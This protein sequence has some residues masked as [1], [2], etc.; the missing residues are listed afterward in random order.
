MPQ[1]AL[2]PVNSPSITS[3]GDKSP[4]IGPLDTNDKSGQSGT[5]LSATVTA[6]IHNIKSYPWTITKTVIPDSWNLF[7]GDIATSQY[8]VDVTKGD[9]IVVES[10]LKGNVVVTNG[11]SQATEGLTIVLKVESSSGI[12]TYPVD[13]SA[14]STLSALES[15]SYSYNIPLSDLGTVTKVTADVTITN[16]SGHLNSP[17]GPNPSA[18]SIQGDN[19]PTYIHESVKVTDSNGMTWTTSKSDSWKY[20]KD[21]G[22]Y[23]SIGKDTIHNTIQMVDSNTNDVLGTASADV[24]INIYDVDP[25]KTVS[26]TFDRK[27]NWD[28]TKTANKDQLDLFVGQSGSIDYTVTVTS[29][30]YVD[31][32]WYMQGNIVVTNNAPIDAKLKSVTDVLDPLY[33]GETVTVSYNGI[34]V[35][36]D[37]DLVVPKNGGKLTFTYS[38]SLVKGDARAN[39]ATAVFKNYKY[40]VDKSSTVSGTTTEFSSRVVGV[41]FVTPAQE[42]DKSVTVTDSYKGAL[43]QVNFADGSKTFT[44]TRAVAA[45][46]SVGTKEPLKNTATITE[47]NQ[48][49]SVTVPVTVYSLGVSKDAVASYD[50]TYLWDITK[51]AD[52]TS[53]NLFVGQ[54]GEINYEVIVSSLGVS[55]TNYH[56]A[57]TITVKNNAPMVATI[58]S[59]TDVVSPGITA[60]V[61]SYQVNGVP[62]KLPYQLGAG[63]TLTC[64]YSAGLPDAADRTNTATVAIAETTTTFSGTADVKLTANE[65]DKSVTVT[66]TNRAGWSQTVDYVEGM[67]PVVYDYKATVG[68]YT[69]ASGAGAPEAT[70][71]NTATY[72]AQSGATD[73]AS[74]SVD[75]YTYALTVSKTAV[76][77]FDRTYKWTITK[78]ADPTRFDLFVGQSGSVDYT[79]TVAPDTPV[80]SNFGVSG[81]ITVSNPAPM[82]ATITNIVDSM[83]GATVVLPE[84]KVVPADG[85]RTFTY[86]VDP[87]GTKPASSNTAT[88]SIQ[89]TSITFSSDPVA[90]MF[91]S[92]HPTHE[93]D[94]TVSVSDSYSGTLGTA[95][96]NVP[97][98]QTFSYTRTLGPY[99][100]A[101]G[102]DTPEAT[103]PNTA[104]FVTS[105]TKATGSDSASVDV[106]TYSL[107]VSKDAI[108]SFD[109]TYLWDITKTA[110]PT[111]M[112]LFVGQ[113]GEINYEV[114]VSS[115]GYTDTN[116]HVAGTITVK[117]NAPMAATINSITDVVSPSIDA[118]VTG[119]KVNGESVSLPYQLAAGATLT[120]TYR[121]NLPDAVDRTNTATV[122]IDETKTTFSGTVDVTLTVNEIDKSVT[123]TDQFNGA[124]TVDTLGTV[125]YTEDMSPVTFSG[126]S[127]LTKSVGP[128]DTPTTTP[129]DIKNVATITTSTTHKS[130]DAD[131]TVQI[132]VV[133]GGK[134]LGYKFYDT[135]LNGEM[136]ANELGIHNWK[137]S[138]TSINDP[139]FVAQE[140][141][142][143]ENG[144]YLFENLPAGEY[145]VK[146]LFPSTP[147]YVGTKDTSYTVTLATGG[148]EECNFGNVALTPGVGGFTI[149]FW[150]NKNGQSLI[151]KDDLVTLNTLNLYRI[152]N[153]PYVMYPPFTS[154]GQIKNYLRNANAVDMRYMLSAQLIATELNVLHGTSLTGSTIIHVGSSGYVTTGYIS[155]GEVMTNANAALLPNNDRSTQEYWKNILDGINNNNYEFLSNVPLA[156]HYT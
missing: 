147:H 105:D 87:S 155:I 96:W 52:P 85:S 7:C 31:S 46:D 29:K 64:T 33:P 30:G 17:F 90:V 65:I 66:D 152:N 56:V 113:T 23:T 75:V 95:T 73:S 150:G 20:T 51:S 41:T 4:S 145:L 78:T 100:H 45:Y 117:N 9:P 55:D 16:H 50:R 10:D 92:S 154:N 99:T 84:D 12:K 13:I 120:C 47:T 5:T 89:G 3:S 104:S 107:G 127:A 48:K 28:I 82:P 74:A 8:T 69:H 111:S 76:T 146:E 121:A 135:N 60:T 63:A 54:T 149:G 86:T 38:A 19:N 97:S 129:I 115:N 67:Q 62:V 42:T 123:V 70:I 37:L 132:T 88:V 118:T 61:T 22:P 44:Y 2:N 116:Y 136:D 153:P 130:K 91:D 126:T 109:R 36:S 59:I 134:I 35:T 94:K 24:T 49:A 93:F 133:G 25:E 131:A 11:G 98:S 34:P 112:N 106:Y 124:E 6:T 77:S 79:V 72:T 128:Y 43:G 103:I 58:N 68:P 140:A 156:P 108:A 40:N 143:N 27:Y 139:T 14:K 18:S 57:G 15:Y 142:T 141:T 125:T 144:Q 81:E 39:K 102:A 148:Y 138:L 110:K 21:F 114:T 53:M 80:D 26:T 83:S 151:T 122:A 71:D 101:S 32:N 119:Y 137:I 1:G